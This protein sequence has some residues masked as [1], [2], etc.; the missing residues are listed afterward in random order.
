MFRYVCVTLGVLS[1]TA[2]PS[3]AKWKEQYSQSP[4]TIQAW[5]RA[6]QNEKGEWC[7]DNADG[8]PYFGSYRL[9]KDGGVELQLEGGRYKIP[10]YMLLK[11]PNPTGHAVW[12]YIDNEV[13]HFDLCFAAGALN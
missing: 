8:H 7:C 9:T 1:V 6:Q 3:S 10:A 5:Y 13:G 12:W 11:G 2:T 4:P